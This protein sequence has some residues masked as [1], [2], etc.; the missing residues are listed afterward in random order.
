[1]PISHTIKIL[2]SEKMKDRMIVH[3][4]HNDWSTLIEAVGADVLPLEYGGTNGK[5]QDHIGKN[6][7]Y[8]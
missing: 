5:V 8:F 6:Y 7:I 1:M 4:K 2:F 3:L